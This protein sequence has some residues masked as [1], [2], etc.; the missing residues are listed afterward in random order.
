MTRKHATVGNSADSPSASQQ[1]QRL[2]EADE[3]L[4]AVIKRLQKSLRATHPELFD[5]RGR[6]RR[7]E[8]ARLLT[9]RT[10]GKEVLS[11]DDLRLLEEEAN[12]V[13]E[14]TVRAP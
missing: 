10:G 8:L 9:A 11:G 7:T 14:R 5:Q 3:E 1:R 12:A 2:Q 4:E 13:A 6:L